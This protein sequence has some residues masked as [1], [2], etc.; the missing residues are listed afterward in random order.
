LTSASTS[1]DRFLAGHR[2]LTAERDY[3]PYW[4]IVAAVGMLP[5]FVD[6][7]N[8]ADVFVVRAVAAL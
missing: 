8:A 6:R 4:D 5:E 7:E 2:A 1:A 3:D